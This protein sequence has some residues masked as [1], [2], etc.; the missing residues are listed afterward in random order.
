MNEKQCSHIHLVKQANHDN[1][2]VYQCEDCNR[3]LKGTLE[4]FKGEV[5]PDRSVSL[6][7]VREIWDEFVIRISSTV[8]TDCQLLAH[9]AVRKFETG[10]A[11]LPT[12]TEKKE[13]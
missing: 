1:K 8:R 10:L 12:A 5:I 11:D 2:D 7:A 4:P 9:E 3:L 6:E 13:S